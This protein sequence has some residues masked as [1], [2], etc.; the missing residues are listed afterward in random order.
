MI[1]KSEP[2]LGDPVA[3]GQSDRCAGAGHAGFLALLAMAACVGCGRPSQPLVSVGLHQRT[4]QHCADFSIEL[5]GR[6]NC[7][8]GGELGVNGNSSVTGGWPYPMPAEVTLQWTTEDNKHHVVKQA[9]PAIP[10]GRAD[11]LDYEIVLL[12]EG[13]ANALAHTNVFRPYLKRGAPE[14]EERAKLD[15]VESTARGEALNRMCCDGGPMYWVCVKNL[16]AKR[17]AKYAVRFGKHTVAGG[18]WSVLDPD[19]HHPPPRRGNQGTCFTSGLPYPITAHADVEWTTADG[20]AF[21]KQVDLVAVLPRELDG[22]CL[23]FFLDGKGECRLTTIRWKDLQAG[24]HPE[25]MQW[26]FTAAGLPIPQ[27]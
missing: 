12:P 5:N 7:V 9:L 6:K 18:K 26:E 21:A 14:W 23:C 24:K 8:F 10:A 11:F 17:F 25:V 1:P 4:G 2:R 16:D 3:P 19:E 22:T 15:D 20:K 27:P 13:R